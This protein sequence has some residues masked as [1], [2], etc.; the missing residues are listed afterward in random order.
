MSKDEIEKRMINTEFFLKNGG[1]KGP[2]FNVLKP[3]KYPINPYLFDVKPKIATKIPAGSSGVVTSRYGKQCSPV[4]S[5]ENGHL[6]APLVEEGCIGVWRKPLT[7]GNYY[8]NP[9]AIKVNLFNNRVQAWVYK[10]GFTP[11]EVHVSIGDDGKINQ[12]PILHKF[13]AI[14][15]GAADAAIQIKTTDKC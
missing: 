14:P 15:K 5:S 6:T 11:R 13:V 12:E 9:E 10:G 7:T 8:F 1:R 2:Q 4:L 3:G